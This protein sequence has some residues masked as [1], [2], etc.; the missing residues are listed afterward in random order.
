MNTRD[1][2]IRAAFVLSGQNCLPATDGNLSARLDSERVLLTRTGIEK[3]DLQAEDLLI[4]YLNDETPD[5]ASSEWPMHRSIYRQRSD[6]NCILHVHSPGLTTFAAAHKIPN[7]NLLAE[8]AMTIGE[9]AL[10]PFAKPGTNLMGVNLLAASESAS[11]Y[12]LSNH[13]A[14]AVGKTVRE[15]LHTLER[16]E[17]LA[18]IELSSHAIGGGVALSESELSGLV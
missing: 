16:A 6:I 4:A 10:V 8:A 12:V 14:V 3:R 1:E 11:V 2:L 15:A 17:F 18:R 5:G 13:G 7:V 9:I